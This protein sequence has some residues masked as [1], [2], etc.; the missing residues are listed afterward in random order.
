MIIAAAIVAGSAYFIFFKDRDDFIYL[1]A[2]SLIVLMISYVFQYQ[3]DQLITRGVPQKIDASMRAMLIATA[4]Y[5]KSLSHQQRELV[6]DRMERWIVKKDFINK[7]EQEAPEDMKYILAY[8]SI[9]LTMHQKSYL[10]DGIDKIVFYHHPFLS[11]EHMDHAHI[12]EVEPEDGTIIISVPHMLKGHVENGYYNVGLHAIAECFY[13]TYIK[14]PI[15]WTDDIWERLEKASGV[16]RSKI[17]A[18]IGLPISDPW[19]VAVHHQLIYK[20]AHISEVIQWIPQLSKENY[21]VPRMGEE[22]RAKS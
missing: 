14:K 18:Y 19:P 3:M 5:F 2:L 20:N 9:L 15:L 22:L 21:E 6:E 13:H 1:F 17:E 10:Y 16:T 4:P 7:N 8:Y 12:S 11:P